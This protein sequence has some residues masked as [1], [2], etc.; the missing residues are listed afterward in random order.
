MMSIRNRTLMTL[1][2]LITALLVSRGYAQSTAKKDPPGEMPEKDY[3]QEMIELVVEANPTLQSQRSFIGKIGA[4]PE[5][6]KA[7][8]LNLNLRTGAKVEKVDAWNRATMPTGSMELIIPLYNSAKQRKVALDKLSTERELARAWYDYYRFKNSTISDLLNK[9][10]KIVSLKNELDGQKKLLSF[11]QHNLEALKKEVEA[12]IGRASDLWRIRE[13]IIAIETKIQNFSSKL[14]IL[15][16][17][18]AVNLAGTRWRELMKMLDK[19]VSQ[20][21]Q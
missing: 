12:G 11:R 8:D 20:A 21:I 19:I 17:E 4:V 18:T 5:P 16:R 9:V 10:D 7:P 6:A 14:D 2:V 1:V 3:L 13:Q 15:K